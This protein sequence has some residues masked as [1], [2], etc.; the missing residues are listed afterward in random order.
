M[1]TEQTTE[2]LLNEWARIMTELRERGI[3]RSSNNPVADYAEYIVAEKLH[4]QLTP[5]SNKS[6]D[7]IDPVTGI[8]YQIKSRRNTRYNSSRILG[9]I[10]NLD[11]ADFQ[12][13][14]AVIF[15]ENFNVLYMYKISKEIVKKYAK[16][17]KHQNGH[18]LRL[19]DSVLKD[20]LIE[21]LQ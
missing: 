16:Y 2:N 10:R 20:E 14:I 13:L 21:R 8:K 1:N 3:L 19:D 11:T 6:F 9:V 7:A 15:D 17:N 12:Y 5:N 18:I 4:L